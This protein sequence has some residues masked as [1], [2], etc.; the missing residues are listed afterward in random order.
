MG[1]RIGQRVG[2]YEILGPIGAGGMGEV[3]R[4]RDTRLD[5]D[6]ALK[7]LPLRAFD[8][9][10]ARARLMREAKLAA[11]LSHP[12]ICTI[13]DVG[14]LDAVMYVA[15]E[16][17]GGDSLADLIPAGGLPTHQVLRYGREI[18]E[19]VAHAH[20]QGIVHRDLKCANIRVTANGRCKVLDFGLATRQPHPLEPTRTAASLDAPGVVA[21][22][23]PYMAPEA[24][25]GVTDP[26]T[27]VW[28]LGVVLYELA[29]GNRPFR[30]DSSADLTSSILRDPPAPLPSH[31]PPPLAS[32]IEHC[33][34]K[35]ARRRYR[36]AGELGAALNAVATSAPPPAKRR[37]GNRRV[38]TL[39]IVAATALLI[40]A[41]AIGSWLWRQQGPATSSGRVVRSVAVLPIKN[42]SD[43]SQDYIAD[44]FTEE[45]I[46]RLSN[47][48]GLTVTTWSSVLPFKQSRQPLPDIARTLGVEG[49]VTG[50]MTR[51]GDRIQLTARLVDAASEESLWSDRYDRARGDLLV[52]QSEITSAISRS[53]GDGS[54]PTER[55]RAS[56]GLT[57]NSASYDL[58]LR[59]RFHAAR[60]NSKDNQQAIAFLERAVESDPQFA[61]AHA[62]L[63]RVYGQRLFYYDPGEIS[64]QE[65]AFVHVE[66]AL[67]LAP[68]LDAA[69]LARGLLLWQ[70]WNHFPHDRA[71][72]SYRRAIELNPNNDEA[73]HQLG[74]V[75]MHV[76]LLDEGMR[77]VREAMRLNPGNTLAHL[78]EGVIFLYQAQYEAA[79]DVFQ[80]TPPDF[81]PSLRTFQLADALFHLGR[82]DEARQQATA[83]LRAQP[84]D[85]GGLNTS[86]QA[87][88]AADQGNVARMTELIRSAEEKGKGY[89]HFHHTAFT[90]ARAYALAGRVTD[91]IAWLQ[92]AADDGY[93]CYPVFV[94]DST[95]N[96]IRGD[97]R[98]AAFLT[99]QQT[100]WEGF[101]KLV[102]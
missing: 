95:L 78:R 37:H 53:L 21:G 2:A 60:E 84:E 16:L 100:R 63:G 36:D 29:S 45:L 30:A 32:V 93:P 57:T 23:L 64:L 58:Y 43:A 38:L 89:G 83:F 41:V 22:T 77:E 86:V 72:A 69:H 98:F 12:A 88:L 94:N 8:D 35:D 65:R 74:L 70:P 34:Q 76:G 10:V 42:T 91:A 4:A 62:E 9:D 61:A 24:L 82:K 50:T 47:I 71:I 55:P 44:G 75:Y 40:S 48:N 79:R 51:A 81:S 102:R 67:A 52:I 56:T 28:S 5:R 97:A 3:Y 11:S 20:E 6:V 73:H 15:M 92:R 87:M 18:A 17:V 66:R 80:R 54:T 33:L 14:E 7:V 59:G 39:S 1:L 26:R 49:I 101:K 90:I 19:G 27:D 85:V 68:D 99:A 96:P 31:V 46:S 13:H 25:R